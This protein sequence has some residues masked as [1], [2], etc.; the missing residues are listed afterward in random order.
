MNPDQL[1]AFLT[2]SRR[3]YEWQP[4]GGRTATFEPRSRYARRRLFP[5]LRA[6]AGRVSRKGLER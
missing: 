1:L 3:S 2:L 4:E 6:A 5:I